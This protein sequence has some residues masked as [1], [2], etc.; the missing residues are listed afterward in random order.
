MNALISV[1]V[2]V[3]NVAPYLRKCINSVLSQTYSNLELILIDD[4][5]NDGSSDICDEY[6]I[7]DNRVTVIHK[8]NGGLSSA[9]NKGLENAKGQYIAFLD[10]DDWIHEKMYE[11]LLAEIVK[12]NADISTCGTLCVWNDNPKEVIRASTNAIVR[13]RKQAL[14]DL[15]NNDKC[16]RFE[17]WNKLYKKEVIN[18]IRF[19]EGQVYEDIYFERMV[20]RNV[21]TVTTVEVPYH[22]YRVARP[23]NTSSSFS[24]SR[25]SMFS[26]LSDF[27]AELKDEG[28]DDIAYSYELDAM[29][30]SINMYIAA[31]THGASSDILL[32]I[33]DYFKDYKK[34]TQINNVKYTLFGLSPSLYLN[35]R[36]VRNLI[37]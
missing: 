25:L 6:P 13:D 15:I 8:K 19:K 9:R 12:A 31:K 28:W 36:K 4:G 33:Y 35:L 30:T 32:R 37:K 20:F 21:N 1:I 23:G 24:S 2:P 17:V 7:I 5:S 34:E 29:E 22:Y 26:E 10:S 14:Q 11:V 27:I 18:S 3:Y 16:I